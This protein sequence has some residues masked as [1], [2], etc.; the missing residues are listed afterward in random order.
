MQTF[1]NSVVRDLIAKTGDLT[2]YTVVMPSKRAGIF[3]KKELKSLLHAPAILP[4]IIGIEDFIEELSNLK[5][6]DNTT[7]PFEFY[8]VYTQLTE[9]GARE[10]FSD[11]IKWAPMLLN[12][13]NEIDRHLVD[14]EELF[15]YLTDIKRL[16]L[17]LEEDSIT[18]VIKNRLSLY[19]N[20]SKLYKAFYD[21]LLNLQTGYQGMQYREASHNIDFYIDHNTGT[22]LLFVGFNALN[23]AEE[24][25]FE[26]LLNSEIASVYWDIDSF[27]YDNDGL[28]SSF[29][30]KYLNTWDYYKNNP[31][32]QFSHSFSNSKRIRIIGTP[33]KITQVK[34]AGEI[35][36]KLKESAK[37][38]EDTALI[39]A[40]ESLLAPILNSFPREVNSV[41]ITMGYEL[42][43]IALYNFFDQLFRL[44]LNASADR[45]YYKD[46]LA[47]LS[48]PQID[49]IFDDKSSLDQIIS[50]IIKNNITYINPEQ[51][52]NNADNH[53]I[54]QIAFLFENWAENPEK[55]IESCIKVI[56]TIRN[57]ASLNALDTEYYYRFY[58][59]FQ[60]L[61]NL[62]NQFNYVSD[63]KTL[64][65]FF[66]QIIRTEKLA[67][68]GEPLSG[69]Q[70]MGMLETRVLD[71]KNL[72]L[73]SVNENILPSGKNEQ[74]FIPFDVKKKY[75]LPTYQEKDAIFAYH[76][77]RLLQR[78]ENIFLIYDTATDSYGSGE[79]SRFIRQLELYKPNE[80]ERIIV[81]PKVGNAVKIEKQIDKDLKVLKELK[82]M[83]QKGLSPTTLTTY[84]FNPFEF[85]KQKVLKISEQDEVEET[86]AANT[87]G[88][89]IHK[90]LQHVYQS[91]QR[92][93]EFLTEKNMQEAIKSIP[94]EITRSFVEEYRSESFRSG[95]NLL[96][97]EVAKQYVAN[98]L[99]SE[100]TMVKNGRK[101]KILELECDLSI[102]IAIEGIPYP[103][104]LIGQADRIDL[105]DGTLR[106]IDY[107]TGKVEQSNL[108]IRDWSQL[109]TDYNKYSKSFQVLFY[110]LLYCGMYKIDP[111]QTPVESGIISFKNQREGFLKINRG[112]ISNA[113]LTAF[114][115]QLRTLISAIYNSKIPLADNEAS[116]NK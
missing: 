48:A 8:K 102:T 77:F 13:F 83:A 71:F 3:L 40:D 116:F 106:I 103:I 39:L 67:F 74:S 97:Y 32:T 78:A 53:D 84:I 111:D 33:K 100:L 10:A 65:H 69:L 12:D 19:S 91:I 51:L 11:F 70:V 5:G 92:D 34:Y 26:K 66:V 68:K 1:L 73:T 17:I 90:T 63:I 44:H 9:E 45:F 30:K 64:H 110:A 81:S 82:D 105:L 55:A 96:I 56:D 47:V 37:N 79:E 21:H 46:L 104:K 98:F 76:F 2:D 94:A 36:S 15:D 29:I 93:K 95:K 38:Y 101:I 57:A 80:V 113:D 75:Q 109:T 42:K 41:N 16:E 54:E 62:N 14:T 115:Q 60:Q 23:K 27:F 114:E 49:L 22:R 107:K 50:H 52:F 112:T 89:I 61:F 85:Y 99:E 72:I 31:F 20:F 58:Q 43:N 87:L 59:I 35:L 88:T 25:I 28:A 86:I 108:M 4:E 18:E 24:T 7:L 6:I